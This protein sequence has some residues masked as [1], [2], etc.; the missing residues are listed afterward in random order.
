VER[1]WSEGTVLFTTDRW[2]PGEQ[3]TRLFFAE[4]IRV[5]TTWNSKMNLLCFQLRSFVGL[6]TKTPPE[7]GLGGVRSN[8]TAEERQLI[9]PSRESARVVPH[10]SSDP[11]VFGFAMNGAARIISLSRLLQATIASNGR[12]V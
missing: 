12:G 9:L 1:S 3:T 8:R 4:G 11:S 6:E 5:F 7:R 2:F 10:R